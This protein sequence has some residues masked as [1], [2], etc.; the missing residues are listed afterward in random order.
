MFSGVPTIVYNGFNNG[1]PDLDF[2]T[3]DRQMQEAKSLGFL[4]VDSYGAGLGGFDSY[5][6][7]TDKMTAAGFTDYSQF[8]RAVYSAVQQHAHEKGWIPVYWT[9]GDEPGADDVKRSTDNAAAYR[10]AF[11]KGPPFFTIP[12]SLIA[13]NRTSCWPRR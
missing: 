4:A 7:D 9:L 13:A 3:A 1:K 8:I 12:T 5:F 6:Q 10:S 11:P 2:T